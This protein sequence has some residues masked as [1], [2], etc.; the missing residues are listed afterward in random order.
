MTT[1]DGRKSEVNHSN[2]VVMPDT[3]HTYPQKLTVV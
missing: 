1:L 3:T 2:C